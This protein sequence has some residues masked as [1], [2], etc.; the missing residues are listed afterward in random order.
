MG[1]DDDPPPLNI[2]CRGRLQ[3]KNRSGIYQL[4]LSHL[5]DAGGA[6][7]ELL[8]LRHD[9]GASQQS[10]AWTPHRR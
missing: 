10:Q 3:I 1:Y 9:N 2:A 7:S 4:W 6:C 8:S 5:G